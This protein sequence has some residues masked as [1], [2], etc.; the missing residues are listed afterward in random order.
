MEMNSASTAERLPKP[1]RRNSR[2]NR[3]FLEALKRRSE[4]LR[5]RYDLYD[6]QEGDPSRNIQE[7][8]AIDW[9]IT[10]CEEWMSSDPLL[11][12][13]WH[14]DPFTESATIEE[15][16]SLI[17]TKGIYYGRPVNVVNAYL[18]EDSTPRTIT[19]TLEEVI[20]VDEEA[21][22]WPAPFVKLPI[23]PSV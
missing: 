13:D 19:L 8:K 15:T 7:R 22:W 4:T 6:D 16:R 12:F 10:I 21:D 11:D 17:G 9:A 18:H 5:E 1:Q 20:G 3:K 2:I 23:S 14:G